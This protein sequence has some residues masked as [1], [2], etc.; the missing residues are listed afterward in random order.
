MKTKTGSEDQ[1]VESGANLSRFVLL[2]ICRLINGVLRPGMWDAVIPVFVLL[3]NMFSCHIFTRFVLLT[4]TFTLTFDGTMKTTSPQVFLWYLF[5]VLVQKCVYERRRSINMH[6]KN[7]IQMEYL[8]Q[9]LRRVRCL[10]NIVVSLGNPTSLSTSFPCSNFVFLPNFCSSFRVLFSR[11]FL[12]FWWQRVRLYSSQ[13]R[14]LWLDEAPR[15]HALQED[16]ADSWPC[17][18]QGG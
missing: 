15:A 13:G 6:A 18:R 1:R 7:P 3:F 17:G 11:H 4:F 2:L 16:W 14:R 10:S 9:N 8:R 12:Q 5:N